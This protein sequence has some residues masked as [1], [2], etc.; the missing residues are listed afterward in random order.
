MERFVK[1]A[2]GLDVASVLAEL[3]R[4]PEYWLR[5]NQ[6]ESE[7]IPLLCVNDSR[8]LEAEL[9]EVWRLIDRLR[10]VAAA[11]LG[12][13]GALVHCRVGRIPHGGGLAPHFDGLNGVTER[14][15][16]LAL[17]SEAGAEITVGG[18][19]KCLRP[20][21]AWQIDV[22]QVH[23]VSNTSGTDRIVILFDS[24]A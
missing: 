1:I 9:P 8:L 15:Y 6:D 22:S 20:G 16:Q 18:E 5:L 11:E 13:R 4:S 23:S 3:A 21:E 2:D 7:Y 19:S 10:D 24:K 17:Q 12:D 14:R